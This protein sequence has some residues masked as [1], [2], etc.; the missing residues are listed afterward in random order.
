MA[1]LK[2]YLAGRPVL[3]RRQTATYRMT[4]F[5]R[6]NRVA[7]AVG[8]FVVLLLLAAGSYSY[9]RQQQA[10]RQGERAVRMQNFLESLLRLANTNYT[11]RPTTTIPEFLELGVQVLP[12]F[13]HDPADRRAAQLSLAESI[14]DNSDFEHALPVF[15]SI[16]RDANA[17][18]DVPSQAEAEGF[19]GMAAAELGQTKLAENLATHA[20]TLAGRKDISQAQRVWITVFYVTA[21]Y[22]RGVRS[23]Q[24]LALLQA[25]VDEA[26]RKGGVPDREMGWAV[27]NLANL[28]VTWNRLDDA[29]RE[30]REAL[31]IFKRQPYTLSD[32]AD[33][34][35]VLGDLNSSRGDDR[36]AQIQYRSAY[37][38]MVKLRG[39]DDLEGLEIEALMEREMIRLGQ[40]KA[41][42][43][44]LQASLPVWHRVAPGN[45][46]FA[47]ILVYLAQAYGQD[48]QFDRALETVRQAIALQ[49]VKGRPP[50]SV[51]ALSYAALATA[52]DGQHKE[53]EALT[54]A[55]KAEAIYAALPTVS[56]QAK[57]YQA[58]NEQETRL[59]RQRTGAH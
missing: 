51:L 18:G 38:L 16:I 31:A 47:S 28:H 39:P 8:S 14:F 45:P 33:L 11:G 43:P 54:A 29:A 30:A 1:D 56:P 52:L 2:R 44:L 26:R 7:L 48:Q 42:I 55:E 37:E 4:K 10:L 34:I 27:E 35:T 20:L 6:R 58:A 40:A 36:E 57:R 17:A 3:A 41:A 9:M 21:R 5:L 24:E 50:T 46:Y 53:P 22:N 59:L 32:Q 15:L 25:T 13:I 12:E 49:E 23:D 19:A